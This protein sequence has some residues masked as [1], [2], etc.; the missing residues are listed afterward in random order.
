MSSIQRAKLERSV[1]HRL[2]RSGSIYHRLPRSGSVYYHQLPRS[3]SIYH[4]LS[5]SGSMYHRF[6]RSCAGATEDHPSDCFVLIKQTGV[7]CSQRQERLC[8]FL[9]Y[10]TLLQSGC[11][12]LPTTQPPGSYPKLS[13][14]NIKG[15]IV[16]VKVTPPSKLPQVC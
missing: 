6:S 15:K 9:C 5:R 8:N 10:C 16:I 13:R 12:L 3:G 7:I 4:R 11:L 2:S 14:G 1:Y